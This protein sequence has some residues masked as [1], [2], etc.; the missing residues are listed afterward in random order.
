MFHVKIL[1]TKANITHR[2]WLIIRFRRG[3]RG[4]W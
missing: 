1:Y 3:T 4:Y 2:Q